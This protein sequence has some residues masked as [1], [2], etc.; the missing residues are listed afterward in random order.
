VG[1]PAVFVIIF[2]FFFSF[3]LAATL[4]LYVGEVLNDQVLSISSAFNMATAVLITFLFPPVSDSVGI[5][6]VFLFFAV[7]MILGGIY[8][9]FDLVETKDKE[10]EQILIEMK[11]MDKKT[12]VPD[13]NV[14]ND[15]LKE[16][17]GEEESEEKEQ[18]VANNGKEEERERINEVTTLGKNNDIQISAELDKTAI[19]NADA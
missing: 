7:M 4:W 13:Q 18:K 17:S 1:L 10:K 5:N 15:S 6:N 12:V 11:V 2:F 14:E 9:F 16:D 19:N 3:S 8:S